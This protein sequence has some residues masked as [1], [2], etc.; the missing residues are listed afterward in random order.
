MTSC[1]SLFSAEK[2]SGLEFF[3]LLGYYFCIMDKVDKVYLKIRRNHETQ[4][5]GQKI[6][7][8]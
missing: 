2:K 7:A 6:N 3:F 5:F 4:K 8:S 1:L